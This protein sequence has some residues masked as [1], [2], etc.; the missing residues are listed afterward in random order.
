MATMA[1]QFAVVN[2]NAPPHDNVLTIVMF[3]IAT[4]ELRA[5]AIF[6]A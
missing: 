5:I 1:T 3:P 2:P 6:L 4:T